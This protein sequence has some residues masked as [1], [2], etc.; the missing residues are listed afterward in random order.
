MISRLNNLQQIPEQI[1]NPIIISRGAGIST[2]IILEH[3]KMV[4]HLGPGTT[5]RNIR[6][7]Y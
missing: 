7:K 1:K 2:L 6:L 3:H 4:A 5:L